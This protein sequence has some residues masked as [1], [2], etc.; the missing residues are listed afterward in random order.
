MRAVALYSIKGGVGKTAAS[1]NLAYESAKSGWRTLVWDLDPQGA[2]SFYFRVRPELKGGVKTLLKKHPISGVKA[3]D[4]ANLDLLP[5]D[6]TY[7][8]LDLRLNDRD[9][10]RRFLSGRLALLREH[11][12]LIVFDCAPSISLVSENVFRAVDIILQP[13][14]P[15]TLSLRTSEQLQTFVGGLSKHAPEVLSFLSMIDRRRKLHKQI[16]DQLSD[17]GSILSSMIPASS[18]V[19]RMGSEQRPVGDF[20]ASSTAA[21]AYASLWLELE[22]RLPLENS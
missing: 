2:A 17:A 14:I 21:V 22:Q 4:F 10:P 7:R 11:Y 18:V 12:D 15:T 20:A 9:K 8:H 19:E 16:A 5:A 13:M 3:T 1:I 6:F